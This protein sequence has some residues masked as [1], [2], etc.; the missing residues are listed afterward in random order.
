MA[1]LASGRLE[2]SQA[3][4]QGSKLKVAIASPQMLALSSS[5]CGVRLAL[6]PRVLW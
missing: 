5:V 1:R 6:C 4:D 3:A 2:G